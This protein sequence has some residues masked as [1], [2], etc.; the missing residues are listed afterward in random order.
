MASELLAGL[1]IFKTIYESEKALRILM[2][3]PFATRRSSNFKKNPHRTRGAINAPGAHE[4]IR[5]SR[6]VAAFQPMRFATYRP[7]QR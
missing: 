7:M 3:L 5:L 4:D 1:G 2:T 6:S